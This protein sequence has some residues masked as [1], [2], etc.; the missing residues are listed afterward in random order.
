MKEQPDSPALGLVR[1]L[2]DHS[3][4]STGHSWQRLNE[5]LGGVLSASIT[6]GLE[7]AADDF[8]TIWKKFRGAWWFGADNDHSHGERFYT[9]AVESGNGSACRSF[10]AWKNRPPFRYRGSRLHV[11]ATLSWEGKHCAVTSFARDGQ[12]LFACAYGL[13]GPDERMRTHRGIVRRFQIDV[14]ELRAVEREAKKK[15]VA[16]GA[17]P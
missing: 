6:G 9:L 5:A 11:G 12:S 15:A 3:L 4:K 2:W 8:A 14:K 17:T 16:N 13:K 7:F 1:H 10:E